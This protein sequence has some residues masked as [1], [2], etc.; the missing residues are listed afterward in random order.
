MKVL[1]YS[2]L[3]PNSSF[4][5]H[6]IFVEQRL[7]HLLSSGEIDCRVVAPVPWFPFTHPLF[8]EYAKFAEVDKNETR[9]DIQIVHPRYPL[10]PK[11]GMNIAPRLLAWGSINCVKSIIDSGFDFDVLDA[12]YFY[13]DGVAAAMIA[14]K[15]NKPF[16][17]TARGTDINLIPQYA[18]PR[19]QILKAAQQASAIIT[20]C[21]ALKDELVNIGAEEG[22]ITVL[23]NG[24][25]LKQFSPA[26]RE[27]V[28]Q[29]LNLHRT[30]LI[31]VGHL[32]KRK[33]HDKVIK[34]L[35]EL[36]EVDLLLIGDGE[37]ENALRQLSKDLK[38]QDRVHFVGHVDQQILPNYYTAAD[39]LVLASSREGWPNVL[40]EAM[41]CGTPVVATPVWGSPEVVRKPEAG[42][43]AVDDS[44][45]G[46]ITAIKDLLANYPDRRLTRAYAELHSWENTTKGQLTLFKQ[47]QHAKVTT[48]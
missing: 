42:R 27:Q 10:L 18:V 8:G 26:L 43:V 37:E 5:R 44:V 47:I 39:M 6:G 46:L 2:T 1:T 29:Q 34:T 22:K 33:G 32:I 19:R 16:V 20:V 40:L 24:V 12:H 30:T 38:L 14:A 17:I 41:A 31:S 9:H 45:A 23:R 21:Q 11:I 36:P 7:R 25:D 3:F 13:P 48:R 4:P 35:L 15:L 28:R